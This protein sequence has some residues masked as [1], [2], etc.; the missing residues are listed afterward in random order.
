MP[1][2]YISEEHIENIIDTYYE[3]DKKFFSD[4]ENLQNNQPA[5]SALLTD[6]S[7]ELLSDD[8][9]ELLWFLATVIHTSVSLN[10]GQ[11]KAMDQK[12]MEEL[13]EKNWTTMENTVNKNFKERLNVFFESYPQEDLLAFVED[14]IESDE[15]IQVSAPGME[16]IFVSCKTLI[17]ALIIMAK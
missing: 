14:S 9:Y 8:E 6:E 12:S 7:Y 11:L 4:R 16:L 1:L 10:H 2:T 5:F 13:E 3:S 15:D 17:D